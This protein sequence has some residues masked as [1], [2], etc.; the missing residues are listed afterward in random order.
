MSEPAKRLHSSLSDS[1]PTASLPAK[2][3]NMDE[4]SCS[5]CQLTT[6]LPSKDYEGIANVG[7][8]PLICQECLKKAS[9]YDALAANFSALKKRFL[10]WSRE[11]P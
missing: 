5:V 10:T 8:L 1:S 6:G 11:W 9:D 4:L 3:I 2:R 7:S